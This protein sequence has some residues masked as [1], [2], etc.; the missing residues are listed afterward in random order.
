MSGGTPDWA[1]VTAP[2]PSVRV[3]PDSA[4]R[5]LGYRPRSRLLHDHT[6]IVVDP[7]QVSETADITRLCRCPNYG[8]S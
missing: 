2:D 8:G 1:G 4:G 6:L 5:N 7:P 3:V